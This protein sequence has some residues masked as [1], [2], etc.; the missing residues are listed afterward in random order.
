MRE[1]LYHICTLGDWT[2]VGHSSKEWRIFSG[3]TVEIDHLVI[4]RNEHN[5]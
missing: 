5:E 1:E 4:N 2:G 3:V